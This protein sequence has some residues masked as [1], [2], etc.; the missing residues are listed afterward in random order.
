LPRPGGPQGQTEKGDNAKARRKMTRG[1]SNVD[2]DPN[3]DF[4]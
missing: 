1:A 2:N 4:K 3:S